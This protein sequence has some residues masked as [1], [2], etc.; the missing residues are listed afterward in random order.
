MLEIIDGDAS[1]ED[2][3]RLAIRPDK[4]V[5]TKDPRNA[6]YLTPLA[7]VD[8]EEAACCMAEAVFPAACEAAEERGET[9]D[10]A[11]RTAIYRQVLID[12]R[13]LLFDAGYCA[14]FGMPSP[15]LV[16]AGFAG[17]PPYS[18]HF[19]WE[20]GELIPQVLQWN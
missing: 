17:E 10:A 7:D 15:E 19:D 1:P 8:Y 20:R 6:F 18:Q 9:L 14:I 16:E 4:T 13:R 5:D 3:A 2:C 11:S 12:Q